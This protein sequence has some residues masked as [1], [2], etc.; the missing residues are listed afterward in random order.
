MIFGHHWIKISDR[1]KF[2]ELS[3]LNLSDMYLEQSDYLFICTKCLII[4]NNKPTRHH[5]YPFYNPLTN[6][7]TMVSCEE[8]VCMEIFDK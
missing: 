7:E 8:M 2:K 3:N 1:H 6:K 4:D 5:R